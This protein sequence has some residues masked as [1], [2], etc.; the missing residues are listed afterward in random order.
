MGNYFALSRDLQAWAALQPQVFFQAIPLSRDQELQLAGLNLELKEGP[1]HIQIIT[2]ASF[3]EPSHAAKVA[4]P[5]LAWGSSCTI[6]LC[7][8]M[9]RGSSWEETAPHSSCGTGAFPSVSLQELEQ[10]LE[11][12]CRCFLQSVRNELCPRELRGTE[13]PA[14]PSPPDFFPLRRMGEGVPAGI[15]AEPPPQQSPHCSSKALI[16]LSR[17]SAS[18]YAPFTLEASVV[19]EAEQKCSLHPAPF[20]GGCDNAVPAVAGA[21]TKALTPHSGE[22]K[23]F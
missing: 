4:Q 10:E 16:A 22:N 3:T 5:P 2:I 6:S 23:A 14:R 13:G 7:T 17:H 18:F 9:E 20:R 19:S 15:S 12:I 1:F 21:F 11:R 8:W